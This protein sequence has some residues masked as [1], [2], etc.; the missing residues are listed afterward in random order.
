MVSKLYA[1][2]N[3]ICNMNHFYFKRNKSYGLLSFFPVDCHCVHQLFKSTKGIH[4]ITLF[5]VCITSQNWT[6]HMY[7]F[8]TATRYFFS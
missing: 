5:Q 2:A 6:P 4:P 1:V 3:T 7:W 8:K